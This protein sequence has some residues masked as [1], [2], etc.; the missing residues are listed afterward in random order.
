MVEIEE[1]VGCCG[2]VKD[3]EK[4][5]EI[6]PPGCDVENIVERRLEIKGNTVLIEKPIST[7]TAEGT[8]NLTVMCWNNATTEEDTRSFAVTPPGRSVWVV[9]W[10]R[11]LQENMA[12]ILAG[13]ML[14]VLAVIF[15][16]MF[17]L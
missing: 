14:L 12:F 11:G 17:V 13:G 2:I 5:L 10:I 3:G 15:L 8:Y 6:Y 16:K 1:A 4:M 7:F 9:G